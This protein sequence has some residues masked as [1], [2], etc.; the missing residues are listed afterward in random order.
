MELVQ[1]GNPQGHGDPNEWESWVIDQKHELFT[2]HDHETWEMLYT[3]QDKNLPRRVCPEYFEGRKR[4]PIAHNLIPNY[5]EMSAVL[6]PLTGWKV[7]AVPGLI[8]NLPFLKMLSMRVF[9][10]GNFIRSQE[11]LNYTPAPDV[12]HDVFGHVPLLAIQE[13]ADSVQKFPENGLKAVLKL[14][15][16]GLPVNNALNGLSRLY[17]FTVEFG[18]MKKAGGGEQIYGAGIISSPEESKFAIQGTSP[19]RIAFDLNRVLHTEYYVDRFQRDYFVAEGFG[20]L[21]DISYDQLED[22]LRKLA[23]EEQDINSGELPF[24]PAGKLL[25]T[26]TVIH[27]GTQ[28]YEMGHRMGRSLEKRRAE[29]NEPSEDELRKAYS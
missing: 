8:P 6:Q 5:E 29:E 14:Q 12:F 7:V 25:D 23:K 11:D 26:D 2:P 13:F 4:L 28:E 16:E 19:N 21:F 15:E 18:L 1:S 10:A 27:R 24:F 22:I 9:P 20:D 17:W 3:C